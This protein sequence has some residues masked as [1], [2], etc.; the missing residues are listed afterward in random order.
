MQGHSSAKSGKLFMVD[1]AGSE[2][3][4]KTGA[5]GTRFEEA[6]KIN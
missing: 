4:H 1:L 5:D 3:A 2:M 6:K